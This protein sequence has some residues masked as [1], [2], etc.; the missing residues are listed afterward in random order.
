MKTNTR[1]DIYFNANLISWIREMIYVLRWG[2]LYEE[3]YIII[4][5]AWKGIKWLTDPIL[6][7]NKMMQSCRLIDVWR[8][9]DGWIYFTQQSEIRLYKGN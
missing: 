4:Q 9:L 3:L 6:L 2:M 7:N 8:L 1:L 5:Y